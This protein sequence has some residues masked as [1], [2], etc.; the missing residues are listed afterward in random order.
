[1]G[2][3][4]PGAAYKKG[5]VI[6]QK[7]EVYGILGAGGFGIVY[8]VYSYETKEVYALKTFRDEYL[9][10]AQTRERFR[11]EANV[12]V[13]LERHPYLVRAHFVEEFSGRLFIAM[14]HI[15][16]DEHGLNTLEGYLRR[17][18]PDLG[19]CLRWAIQ[20]C[21]GMEYAN[22]R[23]IR[24]HRDIKPANIMIGQ[25]EVVKITDFGL[26]GVLGATQATSGIR[27]SIQ[28]GTVGLS[29]Q[30]MEGTGFGTPTHMPPEQF[31]DAASCDERS[32]IYSFGVV[33]F[34]MASGGRLPFLAPLPLVVSEAETARFWKAMRHLHSNAP[35]PKLNSPLFSLVRRCM[36]KEPGTRYQSFRELRGDLEPLLMRQTGETISPPS[37]SVLAAWEWS[38]KGISLSNLGRHEEAVRCYDKALEL[39]PR[40]AEVWN[41]KGDC[42][43][44]L[45]RREEAIR[46]CER[47]LEL[48]PRD[49]TAWNNKG[50]ILDSLGRTEEAIRC[51]DRALELDPRDAKAW[52]NK[53]RSLGTLGRHEDAIRCLDRA[54]ELDPRDAPAWCNKGISLYNL[55]GYE[56]AIRCQ[57][58]VLELDPRDAVA[59]YNKGSGFH[60]LGRHQEAIRCYDK[61][62]ELDPQHAVAWYGKGLAQEKLG[63]KEDAMRSYKQ[64]IALGPAQHSEQLEY[65]QRRVRE[66]EAIGYNDKAQK[67]D[68]TDADSWYNNGLSLHSP[69]RYEE[70]IRCYDKA[71]ELDP[72]H[73][74]AWYSK[75]D[76]LVGLGRHEEAIPCIDKALELDP[77]YAKAWYDKGLSLRHV[78]HHEEAIRCYDKAL[79]PDPQ[80]ALAWYGK[81]LAQEDLGRKHDAVRSYRQ[82]IALGPAQYAEHVAYAQRRVRELEALEAREWYSKGCGLGREEEAMRCFDKALELDPQYAAAWCGKGFRL[83]HLGHREEA[84]RCYDKAL[85]LDPRDARA[86]SNKGASLGALGRHEEAIRC[87]DR[88]LELD[89]RDAAAWNNKGISLA[90]L[91]RH[92]EAVR[93][94]DKALELD[95]R[96]A[97][98]WYAKARAQEELGRSKDAVR[99]YKQ[100]IALGPTEHA[101][102]LK[103]AQ[104]RVRD[105]EEK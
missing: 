21:Y 16:P 43:D 74:L 61:A 65:A 62:L 85:E 24:C 66:L 53:G 18:P 78:G 19:Q 45:G 77:Q 71:L 73:A 95:L 30:T 32:D 87:F 11:K 96:Y 33:M 60:C 39:D 54:L 59:W 83:H 82:F 44:S 79:V 102:Q 81:G 58:K 88:A 68:P 72:R 7:Y 5:D 104:R 80:Y 50:A 25:G 55:G 57:D 46:C 34:Q 94:H 52:I 64:F 37:L 48:N 15:A 28:Q 2:D 3:S 105:L 49:A 98:A 29:G 36:D 40:D 89:P 90:G 31:T 101:E 38:N 99:S 6:G 35:V 27:L 76:C 23:G 13:D 8:L 51:Y 26:A 93:C 67:L 70:A 14:E 63:R 86:W 69:G 4:V 100:F 12:W 10:D 20:F 42:L 56:E 75:G 97:M 1:M 47:A 103:H 22:S 91:G 92:E 17:M 41:N 9:A 84:V